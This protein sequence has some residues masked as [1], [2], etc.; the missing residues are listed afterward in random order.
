VIGSRI[1]K[2]RPMPIL[3][4]ALLVV[5]VLGLGVALSPLLLYR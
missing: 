1:P 2:G 4:L 3:R 5:F